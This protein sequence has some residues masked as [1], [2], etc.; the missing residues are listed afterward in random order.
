M[1]HLPSVFK[2]LPGLLLSTV[3]KSYENDSLGLLLDLGV[4]CLLTDVWWCFRLQLMA[5]LPPCSHS[6]TSHPQAGSTALTDDT[7]RKLSP[8]RV[9]FGH[10]QGRRSKNEADS[11][12]LG[13]CIMIPISLT[14]IIKDIVN[15]IQLIK[16]F[17]SLLQK[18]SKASPSATDMDCR[19][20]V[21][22]K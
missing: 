3:P 13:S 5:S 4:W 17:Y 8:K 1:P 22:Q 12:C 14:H 16:Q 7:P 11:K 18:V 6:S 9:S 2:G 20:Q 21:V 10:S 15:A 19:D